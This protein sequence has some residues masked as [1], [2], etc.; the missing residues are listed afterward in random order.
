[1]EDAGLES[2]ECSHEGRRSGLCGPGTVH[3][4]D[5]NVHETK[6]LEPLSKYIEPLG[7]LVPDANSQRAEKRVP[8]PGC[9]GV[10]QLCFLMAS[11][12]HLQSSYSVAFITG[13][14]LV[15]HLLSTLALPLPHLP[16]L[17]PLPVLLRIPLLTEKELPQTHEDQMPLHT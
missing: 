7:T 13:T 17:M 12:S 15:T 14:P 16:F 10:L 9:C 1:M 6:A 8:I 5:R 11:R 3:P 4:Q 2:G